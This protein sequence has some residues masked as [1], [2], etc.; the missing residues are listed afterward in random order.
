MK[1]FVRSLLLFIVLLFLHV[2]S[3]AQE[4]SLTLLG[5]LNIPHGFSGDTTYFSSCWGWVSPDGR[6]YA[7]LGTCE[8]TSI[9]DLNSDSLREIQFI[10]GP[11]ASYCLREMKTYKQYAYITTE[12]GGGTQ[13]VD[14]SGLPDTAVLV[15][16]F[17]YRDS[18]DGVSKHTTRS[19][20]VTISHGYLYLNGCAGWKPVGGSVIFSLHNDP[21]N[22]EYVSDISSIYFHDTYVRNDTM[23][24]S[25][26]STSASGGLYI[27]DVSDKSSPIDLGK[28]SYSG[29]GTHNAWISMDG[30]YVFTAD[31][32]GA[33]PHN[34]KVWDISDL[35]NFQLVASWSEDPASIVHNV[36]GRGNY[37]YVAHYT[38]G[39]GVIDVH[40]PASPYTAAWYDSYL[41]ESGGY[42][43][44]WGVY[45]YFPSGRWIGSDMQTGLY[46]FTFDSLYPRIRPDLLEPEDNAH[47][48]PPIFRWSSAADQTADPHFYEI[49]FQQDGGFDT[50]FVTKDT[51]LYPTSFIAL[52]GEANYNWFVLVR[53]EFTEV[54]STDT[55][56][57]SY[58][59][60][61]VD[62]REPVPQTLLLK[63]NYPNPF[64][65]TTKIMFDLIT[66]TSVTLKIY[67][68]LGEEVMTLL[69]EELL[70]PGKQEVIFNASGLTSGT[71]YYRLITPHF[72]DSKQMLLIK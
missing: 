19:H 23:Y 50:S 41:G 4:A 1:S 57:V 25:A 66:T 17:I 60:N 29:S 14:L 63:Q 68:A 33:T 51:V 26:I 31:E 11:F 46:L 18:T 34:M 36:H 58:S 49:H 24:A 35:P 6:E 56:A 71:Y 7:L 10:P 43:G 15:K 22:P 5:N 67:N 55:F 69:D 13:I 9:I 27:I 47:N 53:D 44:S 61:A 70:A 42:K 12:G 64:N 38:A 37:V 30:K 62:E 28:I 45:P 20:T 40:N 3:T 16:N 39:M 8:G 52:D 59:F 32:I 54:S 48:P 72:T 21:A 2:A 65:P